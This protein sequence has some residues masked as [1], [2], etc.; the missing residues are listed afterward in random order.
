MLRG[1][2]RESQPSEA[3]TA[4]TA[5]AEACISFFAAADGFLTQNF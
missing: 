2:P 5:A 1:T 3:R 4:A